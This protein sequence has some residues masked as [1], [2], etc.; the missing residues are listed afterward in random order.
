MGFLTGYL[1]ARVLPGAFI[2]ILLTLV[3]IYLDPWIPCYTFSPSFEVAVFCPSDP[4][5]EYIM[6][7]EGKVVPREESN[8]GLEISPNVETVDYSSRGAFVHISGAALN[9]CVGSRI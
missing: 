1:L 7:K 9:I 3:F 6:D 4:F 2:S 5:T 8:T